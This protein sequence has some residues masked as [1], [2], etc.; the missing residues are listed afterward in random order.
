MTAADRARAASILGSIRTP[1]KVAAAR[2]N[3]ALSGAQTPGTPYTAYLT[4]YRAAQRLG[5]GVRAL[6]LASGGWVAV[7]PEAGGVSPVWGPGWH[8]V[9]RVEV[10]ELVPE[11]RGRGRLGRVASLHDLLP[12]T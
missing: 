1:A 11:K 3:G 10:T 12:M 7:G 2:A 8:G 6:Q 4:A 9:A 5:E